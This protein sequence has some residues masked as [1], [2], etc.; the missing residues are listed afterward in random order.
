MYPS[1]GDAIEH[2]ADIFLLDSHYVSAVLQQ[3]SDGDIDTKSFAQ[4]IRF[5][6]LLVN[7][8]SNER[9]VAFTALVTESQ[10]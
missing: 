3:L 4:A 1:I 5:C 10:Q 8:T 6:R 9:K 2:Y 7:A